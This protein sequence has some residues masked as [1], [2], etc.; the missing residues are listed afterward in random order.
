MSGLF[1]EY[2]L[3]RENQYTG[4]SRFYFGN[5]IYFGNKFYFGKNQYTSR[6]RFYFG[7][8]QSIYTLGPTRPPPTRHPCLPAISAKPLS[9]TALKL[10]LP[11]FPC[12]YKN[13]LGIIWLLEV[14]C[15]IRWQNPFGVLS[16]LVSQRTWRFWCQRKSTGLPWCLWYF[17]CPPLTVLSLPRLFHQ[18]P[19]A[20][21]GS[22]TPRLSSSRKARTSLTLL[23]MKAFGM[24]S[25][26]RLAKTTRQPS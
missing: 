11:S 4:R 1:W 9:R 14:D 17:S 2:L 5:K 19:P 18:A 3:F 24:P 8:N 25:L 23:S 12:P 16:S 7:Q 6:S 10:K 21:L 15:L 20:T 22:W 26:K 13:G